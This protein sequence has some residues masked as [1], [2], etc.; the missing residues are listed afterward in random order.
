MVKK[1]F[2][3]LIIKGLKTTTIRL[4]KVVPK[5]KEI[6]IHSGGKP[7]AKA[8]IESVEYKK[9]GELTDEDAKRDGYQTV[10][11][12]LESLE[13]IYKT[14]I[15][16][17]DVVTIIRFRVVKRFNEINTDDIYLGLE[18]IDIAKLAH[19]YILNELS[20]ID[21]KVVEEV[22][23]S[24]SIR[25]ASIKLFGSL[26]KRWIVRKTLRRCLAKL[27]IKGIINIDEKSLKRLAE[28]SEFWKKVYMQ[29]SKK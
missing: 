15:S 9:V 29:L 28:V 7:I 25:T 14:K 10:D 4:G 24:K 22:M 2:A 6:I 20:E 1:E 8:V 3:E 18:P 23:R 17:S 16:S 13:K 26:N 21:K 12:L 11:E 27:V 5:S 19:R